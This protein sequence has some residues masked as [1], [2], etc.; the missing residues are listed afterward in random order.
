MKAITAVAVLA[1]A[2]AGCST[3]KQEPISIYK[4]GQKE[5][6]GTATTWSS[7]KV[8]AVVVD[9]KICMQLPTR[10]VSLGAGGS[11]AGAADLGALLK[12]YGASDNDIVGAVKG[13]YSAGAAP[14]VVATER[15]TF[16]S[17]SL[18]YLCQ[19]A[20]NNS[21]EPAQVGTMIQFMVEQAAKI[22]PLQPPKIG[23]AIAKETQDQTNESLPRSPSSPTEETSAQMSTALRQEL[24]IENGVKQQA[25]EITDSITGREAK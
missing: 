8:A 3:L 1:G 24:N 5:V 7:D 21:L 18:F 17:Y 6:L 23:T 9:R 10:I 14:A 4:N 25:Q 15:T 22:E 12:Q 20:M 13:Y 16:L 19:M 2:C 11:A